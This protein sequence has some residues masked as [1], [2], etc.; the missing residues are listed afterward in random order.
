MI[1]LS[2]ATLRRPH[3]VDVFVK[4]AGRDLKAI[5]AELTSHYP[6][7]DPKAGKDRLVES[8]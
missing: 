4:A 7:Y 3:D 1:F 8:E 6:A 5:T 2:F